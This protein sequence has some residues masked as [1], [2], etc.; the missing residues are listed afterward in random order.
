V[1]ALGGG[2]HAIDRRDGGNAGAT[3]E[4]AGVPTGGEKAAG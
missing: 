2:D 3:S 4:G 1:R